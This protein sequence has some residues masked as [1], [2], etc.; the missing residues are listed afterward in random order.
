[1]SG[2]E[3][4]SLDDAQ[5]P[6]II[7]QLSAAFRAAIGLLSSSY[8]ASGIKQ[9][10]DVADDIDPGSWYS[11]QQ[12][13]LPSPSTTSSSSLLPELKVKVDG[14]EDDLRDNRILHATLWASCRPVF[15][16]NPPG[17]GNACAASPTRAT[18]P[19]D[20]AR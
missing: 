16:P 2:V 7:S 15:I 17:G 12:I 20:P 18:F 19:D 10:I 14:D 4:A 11:S 3:V 9:S 1:M 8:L 6:S 13:A 5:R